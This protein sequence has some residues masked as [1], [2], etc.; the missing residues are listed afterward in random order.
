MSSTGV[1][2]VDPARPHQAVVRRIQSSAPPSPKGEQPTVLE[3]HLRLQDIE[4]RLCLAIQL[5]RPA[6]HL[7]PAA[8]ALQRPRIAFVEQP[9]YGSTAGRSP[10]DLS[11]N[12]WRCVRMILRLGI[13]VVEVGNTK[14]KVY[15]T[16]SGATRGENKV[17]KKDVIRAVQTDYSR[18]VAQTVEGQGNDV[19]DA[20]ILA[21]IGCRLLGTPIEVNE[22]PA[23]RTRALDGLVLPE[24][25]STT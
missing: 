16:G 22:I 2:L 11:G 14:V 20:F 9:P 19:T 3:R 5:E 4:D 25:F 17:T 18:Q 24:G 13:P 6:V 10:H 21:A 8:T 23:T 7:G 1:A 12:W 15:A